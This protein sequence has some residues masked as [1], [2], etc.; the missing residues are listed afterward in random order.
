MQKASARHIPAGYH[1]VFVPGLDAATASLIADR[2]E[3]RRRDPADP[4]VEVLNQRI[5]TAINTSSRDKWCKTL[6]QAKTDRQT[7]P[8]R[9]F[10]LLR[11]LKGERTSLAPNQPNQFQGQ[12]HD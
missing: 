8:S 3:R 11:S 4:E 2:D 10:R 9:F 1:A 12:S 5:T 7:N 6:D